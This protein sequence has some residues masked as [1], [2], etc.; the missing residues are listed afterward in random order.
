MQASAPF[1]AATFGLMPRQP[2]PYRAMTMLAA[3]VDAERLEDLVVG[4]AC[5]S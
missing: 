4:R 1:S 5:R 2:P 3:D